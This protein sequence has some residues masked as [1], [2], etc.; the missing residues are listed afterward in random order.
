MAEASHFR[1][2]TVSR[3]PGTD[4]VQG[5]KSICIDSIAIYG[6]HVAKISFQ[7][8]ADESERK[9]WFAR[10]PNWHDEITQQCRG[11]QRKMT[12]SRTCSSFSE[13]C[14]PP[15]IARPVFAPIESTVRRLDPEYS[16]LKGMT[17]LGDSTIV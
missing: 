4:T 16:S 10:P 8:E 15:S 17:R 13:S 12:C 6:K 9:R 5:T 7:G 1:T 2:A 3:F 11:L 14:E